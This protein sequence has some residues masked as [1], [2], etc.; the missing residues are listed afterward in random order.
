MTRSS[1]SSP[2]SLTTI[3]LHHISWDRDIVWRGLTWCDM[4]WQQGRNKT[5]WIIGIFFSE[6][7]LIALSTKA[8]L[9]CLETRSYIACYL[10][11]GNL[12]LKCIGFC[13]E[14]IFFAW[15]LCCRKRYIYRC[16][17]HICIWYN[18][19][20]QCKWAKL[21]WEKYSAEQID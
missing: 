12:S 14:N 6:T 4:V 20:E 18:N 11:V 15:L 1:N 13:E 21:D 19:S 17:S 16:H 3:H 8:S 5:T 9:A 10:L 2:S 7:P